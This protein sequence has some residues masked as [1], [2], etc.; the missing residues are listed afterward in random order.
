[1]PR[2][3]SSPRH[4]SYTFTLQRDQRQFERVLS[5]VFVTLFQNGSDVNVHELNEILAVV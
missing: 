3:S 2:A 5:T 1:M 4:Y